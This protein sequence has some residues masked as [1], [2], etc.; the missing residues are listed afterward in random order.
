MIEVDP[1]V[2]N[3]FLL[4]LGAHAPFFFRQI[5]PEEHLTFPEPHDILIIVQQMAILH[6]FF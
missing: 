6:L 1:S 4:F 5:S 3:F 2:L